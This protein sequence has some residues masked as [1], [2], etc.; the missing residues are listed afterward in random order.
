MV[1]YS[2]YVLLEPKPGHSLLKRAHN[3]SKHTS[4]TSSNLFLFDAIFEEKNNVSW[5]QE[6]VNVNHRVILTKK[7]SRPHLPANVV[8]LNY[9]AE[10]ML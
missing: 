5:P 10:M 6:S 4:T 7:T 3:N 1:L 9:V 2:F 8:Y